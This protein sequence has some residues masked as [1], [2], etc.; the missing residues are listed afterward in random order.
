MNNEKNKIANMNE[1]QQ[2]L[3][4]SIRTYSKVPLLRKKLKSTFFQQLLFSLF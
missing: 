2:K 3:I 4:N 1:M